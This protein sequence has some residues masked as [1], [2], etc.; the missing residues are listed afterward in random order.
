MVP[1][2]TDVYTDTM[3]LLPKAESIQYFMG[4]EER[5]FPLHFQVKQT[6]GQA[7]MAAVGDS[8]SIDFNHRTRLTGGCGVCVTM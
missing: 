7:I 4:Q 2:T 8:H 1:D 6:I 5:A 3:T